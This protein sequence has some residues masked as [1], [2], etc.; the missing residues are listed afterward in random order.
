M[1]EDVIVVE[2][3]IVE[4]TAVA[5]AETSR[6]LVMAGIGAVVVV[7][8]AVKARMS[9]LLEAEET[10][11]EIESPQK[12]RRLPNPVNSL[13]ERL[14]VPTKT[15]I[16][17]LNS[18]VSALLEKIEALQELEGQRPSASVISTSENQEIEGLGE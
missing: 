18:Q 11:A 6:R 17:A 9:R 5:P 13:R 10:K 15:D 7:G 4:V 12:R 1:S 14:N 2:E 16:D 3:E 8:G